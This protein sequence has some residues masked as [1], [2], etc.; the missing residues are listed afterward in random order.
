MEL[1]D[2]DL[3]SVSSNRS[4]G[5]IVRIE[6]KGFEM[7]GIEPHLETKVVDV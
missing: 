5:E 3:S 6:R 2:F 1:I 7:K 4:H